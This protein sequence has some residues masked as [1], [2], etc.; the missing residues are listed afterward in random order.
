[1]F[2]SPVTLYFS[3][4]HFNHPQ[5]FSHQ[6][7]LEIRYPLLLISWTT[8]V[9]AIKYNHLFVGLESLMVFQKRFHFGHVMPL[10][11]IWR[12]YILYPI[13][14]FSPIFNVIEFVLLGNFCHVALYVWYKMNLGIFEL[15]LLVININVYRISGSYYIYTSFVEQ[16]TSRSYE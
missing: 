6:F 11:K 10:E 7:L 3:F 2:S 13:R 16:P 1:M 4:C 15:E 14:L 5:E 12:L 8:L 9:F